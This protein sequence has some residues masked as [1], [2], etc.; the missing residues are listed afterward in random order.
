MTH[1]PLRSESGN[2][3]DDLAGQ[4]R[5]TAV[6]TLL[7]D[8]K[9]RAI[10]DWLA[11]HHDHDSDDGWES[12][13]FDREKLIDAFEQQFDISN[14]QAV[15]MLHHTHLPRLSEVGLLGYDS[16]NGSIYIRDSESMDEV[17]EVLTRGEAAFRQRDN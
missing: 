10:I 7:A 5:R 14:S 16:A 9:R 11:D 8:P 3:T 2:L 6:Y 13:V 15:A 12:A 4:H 1:N 17:V